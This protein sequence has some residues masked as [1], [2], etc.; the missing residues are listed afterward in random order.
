MSFLGGSS[1]G[2]TPWRG[3]TETYRERGHPD[4]EWQTARGSRRSY[5]DHEDV[6]WGSSSERLPEWSND[7]NDD[8]TTPGTFDSSGAFVSKVI[9]FLTPDQSYRILGTYASFHAFCYNCF[10]FFSKRKK[11]REL[12]QRQK[13]MKK[14]KIQ[15]KIGNL[16]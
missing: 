11:E 1:R 13:V 14:V 6:R 8:F 4:D 2:R 9:P 16:K 3:G 12:K 15:R 7:D 10:V 5:H